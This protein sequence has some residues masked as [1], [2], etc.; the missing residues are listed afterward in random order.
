MPESRRSPRRTWQR[1]LRS[2][3]LIAVLLAAL[4]FA[5]VVQSRTDQAED[6][7]GV[8]GTELAELLRSLDSS[9]ERLSRQIDEL[10][11]T[12]DDLRSS[13]ESAGEAQKAARKRAQQLSI[14]AGTVAVRGPGIELT[15]SGKDAVTSSVL[16]DAVEELRDAGA[17][18][19]AVNSS[20]R[21]VAATYFLDDRDGIRSG[22]KVLKSPYRIDVIGDPATLEQAMQIRGGVVQSVRDAG[23]QASVQRRTELTISV[24]ADA[25]TGQYAQLG[26]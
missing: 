1:G 15:L 25:P 12:R 10:T 4:G 2:K 24:L 11:T 7:S 20:V 23:G 3:L 16:I 22:A 19:I 18:S 26:Q 5:I 21:V 6:Y 8:R 14:L 13:N 17:E 9:N